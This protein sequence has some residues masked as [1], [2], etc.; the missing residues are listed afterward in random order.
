MQPKFDSFLKFIKTFYNDTTIKEISNLLSLVSEIKNFRLKAKSRSEIQEGL[1]LA[2]WATLRKIYES[3]RNSFGKNSVE[4]IYKL[5]GKEKADNFYKT[6]CFYYLHSENKNLNS[7]EDE[8]PER[9]ISLNEAEETISS[10]V[11]NLFKKKFCAG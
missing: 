7:N 2:E 6:A 8:K 9:K 5:I 3:I 10:L 11:Q 4:G 1:E